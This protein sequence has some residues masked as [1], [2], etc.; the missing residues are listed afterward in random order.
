MTVQELWDADFEK[1]EGDP[2]LFWAG[3]MSQAA[4]KVY[5]CELCNLRPWLDD[6]E[7]ARQKYDSVIFDRTNKK[8]HEN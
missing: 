8:I 4:F 7:Y 6:L 5:H 2:A 3:R 1:F